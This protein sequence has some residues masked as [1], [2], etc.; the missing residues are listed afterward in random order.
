[1]ER[2]S[3]LLDKLNTLA[4]HPA[5][6]GRIIQVDQNAEVQAAYDTWDANPSSAQL[7]NNVST[8]IKN[9]LISQHDPLPL[10]QQ[11]GYLVIVGDDRV[12][13]FH[14]VHVYNYWRP[15]DSSWV[16]ESEYA[17]RHLNSTQ[18]STVGAAL[19]DNQTLTDDFYADFTPTS[20]RLDHD[21]YI[22]DL[23]T[24]RLVEEPEEMMAVID[25]FLAANGQVDLNSGAVSGYDFIQDTAQ[26][27]YNTLSADGFDNRQFVDWGSVLC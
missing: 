15:N 26:N 6:A 20:W 19:F 23:A 8:A 18:R 5:V 12:I 14:R 25:A 7:A 27:Q 21:L 3:L 13:P 22:P 24:G 4:N 9:Y 11:N 17:N 10:M 16:T 2:T 1:M